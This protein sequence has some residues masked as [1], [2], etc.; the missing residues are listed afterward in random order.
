MHAALFSGNSR[1][2]CPNDV[3][4]EIGCAAP[5]AGARP[6]PGPWHDGCEDKGA[7]VKRTEPALR[8]HSPMNPN[9]N[10]RF[11]HAGGKVGWILLWLLGVPI[12]ILLILFVLRG[13]T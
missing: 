1:D 2:F 5:V 3:G 9:L 12:P 7:S 11:R 10:Q 6:I 8:S 13:C 4:R